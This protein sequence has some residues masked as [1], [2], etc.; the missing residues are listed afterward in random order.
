VLTWLKETLAGSGY[1]LSEPDAEDWGWYMDVH[2]DGQAYLIGASAEL[3][4]GTGDVD[5]VVQLHKNRSLVDK[6]LRRN[7]LD[8]DDP[9][10]RRLESAIRSDP[11]IRDVVVVV[12]TASRATNQ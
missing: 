12:E 5:W 11:H 7:G 9:V 10:S 2:A 6:L 3:T 8:D 4:E 1:T